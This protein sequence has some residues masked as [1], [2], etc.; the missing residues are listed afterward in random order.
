MEESLNHRQLKLWEIVCKQY[1]VKP[2]LV[3][4]V[5]K[6]I[7]LGQFHRYVDEKKSR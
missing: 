2:G 4:D 6:K 5:K 3:E 1:K 7:L